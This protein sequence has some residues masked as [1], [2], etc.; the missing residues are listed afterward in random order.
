ML[1][2]SATL[3]L[4]FRTGLADPIFRVL[5]SIPLPLSNTHTP[6]RLQSGKQV[7]W[8]LL[9]LQ[10]KE[11]KENILKWSSLGH[12]NVRGWFPLACVCLLVLFCIFYSLD[13]TPIWSCP[14]PWC[15]DVALSAMFDLLPTRLR[16]FFSWLLPFI[17]HPCFNNVLFSV[18]P[19]S[20]STLHFFL[21]LQLHMCV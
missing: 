18:S 14:R 13:G 6:L 15:F 7:G 10:V 2:P 8:A 21:I 12:G 11:C 1:R 19:I 20:F 4:Y 16:L 5:A 3:S 17:L 9:T